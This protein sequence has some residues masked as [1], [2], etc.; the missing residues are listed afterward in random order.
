[1]GTNKIDDYLN[2]IEK[3]YQPGDISLDDYPQSN[4]ELSD[5]G[6]SPNW[7]ELCEKLKSCSDENAKCCCWGTLAF[8]VLISF[9]L[10]A[11][12]VLALC[13][14]TE[15]LKLDLCTQ[16][17]W[18]HYVFIIFCVAAIVSAIV[19]MFYKFLQFQAKQCETEAKL[20]EK[21]MNNVV[22]A[23][24]EDREFARLMTKT[25]I[26][27]HD[28]LEKARIEEWSRNKENQRKLNEME[29][30][31]LS[32]WSNAIKE[33]AK[34][35]NTV[36]IKGADDKAKTITIER[37]VLSDD[38]CNELKGIVEEALKTPDDCCDAIKK[39]AKCLFGGED[40]CDNIKNLFKCLLCEKECD[41]KH[42]DL[43]EAIKGLSDTLKTNPSAV[44]ASGLQQVVNINGKEQ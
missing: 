7:E 28:K 3:P 44:P 24:H 23:F 22:E 41:N 1:M 20:K 6:A 5:D 37:S 39:V 15:L 34:T 11:I 12:G 4:Y 42:S 33:L 17:K 10:A 29:Q 2:R 32:D 31:R 27:L 26:A 43:V 36:T 16:A 35:K 9:A 8:A 21:M 25:E 19:L 40:D 38:C 30:E 14:R 18:L 13:N